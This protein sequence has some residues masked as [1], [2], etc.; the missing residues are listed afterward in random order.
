MSAPPP[1]DGYGQYPQQP[2]GQP[3]QPQVAATPPP[4]HAPEG[5][6]KK[7]KRGYAA[8]AFDFGT[9]VNVA[10]A[11]AAAAPPAAP[12]AAQYGMPQAQ[13]PTYGGYPQ[14]EP[15]PA[16]AGYPGQQPYG[17]QQPVAPGAGGYQAP[18][19]YYPTPGAVPGA[20]AP[21]GVAGVTAGM[22]QMQVGPGQ[23]PVGQVP[24][25]VALNQ[26]YPTDLLNQPFNV[27]E[28]DLPPPPII[29]PPNVCLP[30]LAIPPPSQPVLT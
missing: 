8:Q 11:A 10:A 20:A 24:Q 6:H 5:D 27:S 9:G 12:A 3:E 14:P 30:H 1:G 4:A 7:Q 21:G 19:A 18:D 17:M 23:Q 16:V 25:A 15:Q 29:L 13:A 26:L 22:A 2:Y 28:L